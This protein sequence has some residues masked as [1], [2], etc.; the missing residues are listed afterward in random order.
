MRE[1]LDQRVYGGIEELVF[2]DG[3]EYMVYEWLHLL[4]GNTDHSSTVLVV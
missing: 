2:G 4:Y 3:V 1:H